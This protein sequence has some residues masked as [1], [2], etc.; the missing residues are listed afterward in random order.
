[1]YKNRKKTSTFDEKC[2]NKNQFYMHKKPISFDSIDTKK[3]VLSSKKSYGN[4]YFIG[5]D[6]Y[7][8]S[9]IPLN[10]RLP[11]INILAKY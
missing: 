2:F 11:P 7:S 4:Q 9:I 3:I 10:I 5:Y 1:M 8:D 6:D